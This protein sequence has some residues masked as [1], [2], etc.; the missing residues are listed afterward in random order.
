MTVY[1]TSGGEGRVIR[2][3]R[4]GRVR[5]LLAGSGVLLVTINNAAG[6]TTIYIN[7]CTFYYLK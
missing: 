1:M 4:Q 2:F 5:K 3:L 7:V 6:N